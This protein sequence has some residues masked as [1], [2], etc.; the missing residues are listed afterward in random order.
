MVWPFQLFSV[1]RVKWRHSDLWSRYDLHVVGH[2]VTSYFV[3][4]TGEDLSRYLNKIEPV[5]LRKAACAMSA[6]WL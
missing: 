2:D 1:D 5:S 3:K 4:L 6:I